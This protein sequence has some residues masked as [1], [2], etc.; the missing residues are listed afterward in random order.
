MQPQHL[1]V[2]QAA[3]WPRRRPCGSRPGA[4]GGAGHPPGRRRARGRGAAHGDR[5]PALVEGVGLVEVLPVVI[6]CRRARWSLPLTWSRAG[7]R[8]NCSTARWVRPAPGQQGGCVYMSR[9]GTSASMQAHGDAPAPTPL[10][11]QRL[12]ASTVKCPARGHFGRPPNG[13]KGRPCRAHF[14]QGLQASNKVQ[15]G[16]ARWAGQA[17]QG[18][19]DRVNQL[20]HMK[21]SSLC[22]QFVLALSSVSNCRQTRMDAGFL[23]FV[24][25]AHSVLPGMHPQCAVQMANCRCLVDVS[26]VRIAAR[27]DWWNWPRTRSKACACSSWCPW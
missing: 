11:S 12:A 2:G 14:R 3:T 15:A 26:P 13:A 19:K 10:H 22:P 25:S 1:A 20:H 4:T 8:S 9:S 5:L 27:C 17:A 18:M 23:Q 24:L 7:T 21:V 6:A 16:A